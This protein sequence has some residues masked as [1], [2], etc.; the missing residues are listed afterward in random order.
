MHIGT[1]AS[2]LSK[3]KY[4]HR[5]LQ[6]HKSKE[7]RRHNG[8]SHALHC[9]V[10]LLASMWRADPSSLIKKKTKKK[11]I[12]WAPLQLWL[13]VRATAPPLLSYPPTIIRALGATWSLAG[14]LGSLQSAGC[15]RGHP[16]RAL[17]VSRER[18]ERG[19][20]LF[21]ERQRRGFKLHSARFF[22]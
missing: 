6:Q 4:A 19:E 12:V 2:V 17:R 16:S 13:S 22:L 8:V 11:R 21:E 10:D 20:G 18:A 5:H 14:W 3:H 15:E 7:Q 1:H 9:G